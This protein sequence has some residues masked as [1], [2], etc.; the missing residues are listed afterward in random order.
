MKEVQRIKSQGDYEAAKAL[1]EGYGVQV[2]Q[3]L[4][5]EVLERSKALGIA[6]YGGFINPWMEATRDASGNIESVELSYPDNFTTQMKNYS[7]Q[8]NLLPDVNSLN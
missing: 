6:P 4:H 8:F 1:V 7:S 3:E 5:A 2:D